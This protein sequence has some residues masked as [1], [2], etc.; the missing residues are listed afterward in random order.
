M[1]QQT[2]GSGGVVG[3]IVDLFKAVVPQ[4]LDYKYGRDPAAVY[5]AYGRPVY[6]F[7]PA[8]EGSAD[9][10]RAQAMYG[11]APIGALPL[12][13]VILLAV[14]GFLLYKAV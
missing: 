3:S 1:A 6:S 9:T 13:T 5:D 2:E 14:G 10:A 12:G 7:G 11:N 8:G 4:Y